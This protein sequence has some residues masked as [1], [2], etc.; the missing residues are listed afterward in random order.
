MDIKNWLINWFA[1]KMD[2]NKNEIDPNSNFFE[3]QYIDSLRIFEL[4][5]ELESTFNIKFDNSDFLDDKIHSINGLV[6]IITDKKGAK[7]E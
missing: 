3:E 4:I 6:N 7:N 2:C 5:V 1:D